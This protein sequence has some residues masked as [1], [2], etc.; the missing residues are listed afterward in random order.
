MLTRSTDKTQK[1]LLISREREYGKRGLGW[2]LDF[3]AFLKI[4][5]TPEGAG[6]DI[7]DLKSTQNLQCASAYHSDSRSKAHSSL[8]PQRT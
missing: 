5:H 2:V 3:F 7:G 1:A 6:G 4:K 8:L